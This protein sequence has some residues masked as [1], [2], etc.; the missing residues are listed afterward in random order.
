MAQDYERKDNMPK[1]C[2][3]GI[4]TKDHHVE[5]FSPDFCPPVFFC[6]FGA[7]FQL[8]FFPV[9]LFHLFFFCFSC[10]CFSC[11]C[12]FSLPA[13]WV[14][15][16]SSEHRHLIVHGFERTSLVLAFS[17]EDDPWSGLMKEIIRLKRG[18]LADNFHSSERIV[19]D[20]HSSSQT[21]IL[22]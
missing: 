11:I 18:P 5:D 3:K 6:C 22:D 21:W 7:P 13:V 14:Q 2:F 17:V 20:G 19:K 9:S 8:G 4:W 10:L 15:Y 16:F 12:T 1:M